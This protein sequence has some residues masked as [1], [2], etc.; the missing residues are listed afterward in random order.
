[1]N[2]R[3]SLLAKSSSNKGEIPT[4]AKLVPHLRAVEKAA[5]G[6]VEVVGCAILS[7]ADLPESPWGISFDACR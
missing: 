4:H 7:Q 1:M 2:F 6:I 3:E 5:E